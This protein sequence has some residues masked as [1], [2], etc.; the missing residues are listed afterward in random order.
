MSCDG[1]GVYLILGVVTLFILDV[2]WKVTIVAGSSMDDDNDLDHLATFG[3]K[4][5]KSG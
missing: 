4:C 1:E 3:V 5:G 2:R